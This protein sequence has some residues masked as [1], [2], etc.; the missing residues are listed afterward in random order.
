MSK[1]SL[2]QCHSLH[3]SIPFCVENILASIPH[4]WFLIFV[5][6]WFH[7]KPETGDGSGSNK[8]KAGKH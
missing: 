5:I 6:F 3:L 4:A 2:Q 7:T 1:S 8:G